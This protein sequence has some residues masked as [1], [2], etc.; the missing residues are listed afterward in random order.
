MFFAALF[1]TLLVAFVE[2]ISTAFHATLAAAF[3]ALLIGWR[4]KK[5]AGW[6]KSRKVLP[7]VGGVVMV[8]LVTLLINMY[9]YIDTEFARSDEIAVKTLEIENVLAHEDRGDR[10]TLAKTIVEGG[11]TE[12]IRKYLGAAVLNSFRNAVEGEKRFSDSDLHMIAS[13]LNKVTPS[14]TGTRSCKPYFSSL[15]I[16]QT[17]PADVAH[18]LSEYPDSAFPCL[19]KMEYLFLARL[20]CA[21]AGGWHAQC[22]SM[23]PRQQLMD[24]RNASSSNIELRKALDALLI[25]T[26]GNED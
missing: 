7:L 2:S 21:S 9:L 24:L 22:A 26:Y 13:L 16:M 4:W 17:G 20:R 8:G 25:E 23:L 14:P 3:V 1:T 6:A 15:Y 11:T 18:V 19:G 12:T 10:Y 5:K